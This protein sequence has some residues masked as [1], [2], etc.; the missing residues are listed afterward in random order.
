VRNPWTRTANFA[1]ELVTIILASPIVAAVVDASDTADYRWRNVEIAGG[2]YVPDVVFNESEPG[3]VYARIDIG[4]AYRWDTRPNRWMP[5]LDWVGADEWGL[6]GVDSI[7]T[8]PVDSD[9]VYVLAGTYTNSWDPN[10]G[11]ILRSKDRGR[12]WERTPLPFKSGGNMPGRNQGERLTI[13]P[14]DH[15]ILFLGTDPALHGI[16]RGQPTLRIVQR[17]ARQDSHR[18]EHL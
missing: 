16:E 1:R 3:L 18:S 15:R 10:N 5:L 12:T 4:G 9:R 7:A 6:T 2:G 14:N 17:R 13:D 11:A 8:D